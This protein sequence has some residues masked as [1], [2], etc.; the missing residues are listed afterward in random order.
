MSGLVLFFY[1][2]LKTLHNS[3]QVTTYYRGYDAT[4]AGYVRQYELFFLYYQQV[5]DVNCI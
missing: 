1:I 5:N 3:F 4:I 2:S